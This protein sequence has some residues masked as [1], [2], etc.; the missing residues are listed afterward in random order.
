MTSAYP[1]SDSDLFSSADHAA[2][3]SPNTAIGPG[4]GRKVL[5]NDTDHSY[6]WTSLQSDG[7]AAQ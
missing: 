3:I 6:G 4:D 1:G 7:P 2:W 5:L